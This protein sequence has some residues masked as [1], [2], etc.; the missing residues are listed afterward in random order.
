MPRVPGRSLESMYALRCVFVTPVQ[1]GNGRGSR[2][3]IWLNL[4]DL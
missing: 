1:P 2:A 4:L 3:W